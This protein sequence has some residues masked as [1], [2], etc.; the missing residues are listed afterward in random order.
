[1]I[2]SNKLMFL[3]QI[4]E[5][6]APVS[7]SPVS[8]QSTDGSHDDET[9]KSFGGFQNLLVS[10]VDGN[11]EPKVCYDQNIQ[12]FSA[13]Y[14]TGAIPVKGDGSKSGNSESADDLNFLL[15]EPF[16]DSFANFPNVDDGFIE[17][18]DLSNPFETDNGAFDML[19]EYLDV[20][21][22]SSLYFGSD[23][24]MIFGN[25]DLALNQTLLP[26]M[27]R[28][29]LKLPFVYWHFQYTDI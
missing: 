5:P 18:N 24:T 20:G 10:A 2:L 1:M 19:A 23:P 26:Q 8:S 11:C 21:D 25:E 13:S 3:C 14:D 27:V 15:N 6:D 16:L 22:D 28:I 12:N 17:A 4:L 29:H 7:I 9:A